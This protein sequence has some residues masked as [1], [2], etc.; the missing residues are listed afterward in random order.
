LAEFVEAHIGRFVDAYAP[1]FDLPSVFAGHPVG[2]D[3]RA[4][5][6]F[7]LGH[8]DRYGIGQVAGM[9]TTKAVATV[10]RPIDGANTHTFFS[11]RVAET[12]AR[13]G[14]LADNALLVDWSDEERRNIAAAC[15]TTT[16]FDLLD[17][18]LP[19]NYAAVLARCEIARRALGVDVDDSMLG[20]LLDRTRRLIGRNRSGFIDDSEDG[21]GAR[22]D[23]YSADVYLFTE[24]FADELQPAWTHGCRNVLDAVTAL[25]STDGSAMT[26]GRSLGFLAV[27]HTIELASLAVERGLTDDDARWIALAE[28]ATD[29]LPDWMQD[30]ITSSH[31][32][33]SQNDYRGLDRWLQ[34]TF[35]CLGKLAWSAE[36]LASVASGTAVASDGDDVD[37]FTDRDQLVWFDESRNAGAWSFRSPAT[38]FVV[39][40]VGT[41][42]GDYAPVP[43]NPGL[44]EVPVDGRVPTGVPTVVADGRS[45]VAAGLPSSFDVTGGGATVTWNGFP[46]ANPASTRPPLA[47]S[48]VARFEAD[49]H[50][51][52]VS[53]T[54][55][56]EVRP[57]SISLQWTERSGRPLRFEVESDHPHRTATIDTDGVAAF[58]SF[59]GELSRV[60]QVDVEPATHVELTWSVRP[61]LRVGVAD[62]SHHYHR[63]LYDPLAGEVVE[64]VVG[65]HLVHRPTLARARLDEI[66]VFH[67]HWPEWFI[68]VPEVAAEF[69]DLLRAT[70]TTL[71]WT[72]HN[73]RPHR[74]VPRAFELYQTFASAADIVVHHSRW[75]RDVVLERYQ[76]RPDAR[77]LVLPHGH[78][79]ELSGSAAGI[80]RAPVER[81]L[82][83]EPCAIR[84]AVVGAPRREKQ[85]QAFMDVFSSVDRDDLQLLVLSL[86]DEKVPDDPRI[87][88][89]PYEFVAREV[90]NRRLAAVD[91][92]ALPFDPDGEMLTTGVAADAI[93]LGLPAIVSSWPYLT[94]TMG[95]AGLVYDSPG[96]L[97]DLLTSLSQEQLDHAA[98]ACRE[99]QVQTAWPAIARRLFDA[100]ITAGAIK[101]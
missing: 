84:I 11:Y 32:H 83:L 30:G 48:R 36:R 25:A 89:S 71:L 29:R 46:R 44:F 17:L 52:V 72:Q 62:V 98:R 75:G 78:F 94:E 16:W 39:P 4:D 20:E 74:D 87:H 96:A 7:T 73:L 37:P 101:R 82:G 34:L 6:A 24:G 90:Y 9:A 43:R 5:L 60:L 88:A 45:Y 12:L 64:R 42:W 3:V 65:A 93:G 97:A 99:R 23:I 22:Y 49:R 81:E 8:L 95:D 28:N 53:E 100:L 70:R 55:D 40:F 80:E 14:G 13:Y 41:P 79:G 59:W 92:L 68:D 63:S 38:A 18:G 58:R 27:C 91:V 61:L 33:R 77:H 10:L 19:A 21:R 47:A 86:G 26:W 56:F 15:D 50:R 85:V 54:L 76:F 69:V 1:G 66:D 67:L 57:S 51:F 35:D 2:P 31:A